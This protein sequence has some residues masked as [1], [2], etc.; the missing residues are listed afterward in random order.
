VPG[1]DIA[2]DAEGEATITQLIERARAG[3]DQARALLFERFADEGQEGD[4]LIKIAR[5]LLP[6]GDRMRD[7]V[8]SRD[9][10][11]SALKTGWFDLEEFRGSSRGEFI[12]WLRAIIR[13]KLGRIV[14]KRI[15]APRGREADEAAEAPARA[16]GSGRG[17]EDS[18]AALIREEVEARVRAAVARLPDHE[19]AVMEMRLQGLKAPEIAEILGVDAAAV[20]KRESRA[21]EKLRA[22]LSP[23]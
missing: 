1:Y 14:R 12:A 19:R 6:R 7:F 16:P 21:A 17:E 13:R 15:P 10:I 23:G 22:M 2:V 9:L 18:L 4:A 20:R 5:R 3:D 11:Q 8:E